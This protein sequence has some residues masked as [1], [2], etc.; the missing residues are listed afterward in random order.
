[1]WHTGREK[2]FLNQ[3]VATE[4]GSTERKHRIRINNFRINLNKPLSKFENYDTI[5]ESRKLALFSNFYLPIVLERTVNTEYVYKDVTFTEEEA[6]AMT[7]DK[8][9]S[10]LLENIED[11]EN[12]VNK[13]INTYTGDGFI[14]VEVIIEVL[15]R[16]GV[17]RKI[18]PVSAV[19]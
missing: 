7:A 5:N 1:V 18:D 14:E 11:I 16:I 6:T 17:K 2:V 9:I 15:E 12:I 19:E 10:M 13:Q 4:T 3:R 8:I